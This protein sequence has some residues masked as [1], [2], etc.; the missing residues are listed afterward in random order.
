[1]DHDEIHWI[2][3]PNQWFCRKFQ[4]FS[5]RRGEMGV[6]GAPKFGFSQKDPGFERFRSILDDPE[7]LSKKY[8][9]S[10][11]KWWKEHFGF[12][13]PKKTKTLTQRGTLILRISKIF[14]DFLV[15]I[16]KKIFENRLSSQS[17]AKMEE[18]PRVQ[19]TPP[20][21][22]KTFIHKI[23]ETDALCNEPCELWDPER[24]ILREIPKFPVFPVSKRIFSPPAA[25]FHL[26]S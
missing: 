8:Y 11:E 9:V 16:F 1:M 22:L 13:W 14:K 2:L 25:R 21:P 6:G 15:R 12:F 19:K 4:Y 26:W 10:S 17:F 7:I 24:P 3:V 20:P 5:E 18:V 23:L